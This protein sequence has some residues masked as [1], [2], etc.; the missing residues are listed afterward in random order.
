MLNLKII[1]E[2]VRMFTNELVI[3]GSVIVGLIIIFFIVMKI[4]QSK[5]INYIKSLEDEIYKLKTTVLHQEK[6]IESSKNGVHSH[7]ALEQ[8]KRVET[9][10]AEVEKQKKRVEDAKAIAQESHKIKLEFLSNI[11]E[12]ITSPMNAIIASSETLFRKCNDVELQK[13]AT[14]IY[15]LGKQLLEIIE[16]IVELSSVAKGT[17]KIE[18][19]PVDVKSVIQKI[20]RSQRDEARRKGLEL[21]LDIDDSLP[22]ALMLDREK[23]EDIFSNLVENAVKFTNHGFVHVTLL[24]NGKDIVKNS[25]NLSLIV[26]DSGPGIDLKDQKKIF[27]I[28]ENSGDDAITKGMGL[29]LS[30]HKRIAKQMNGDI[31]LESTVDKGSKF[32]FVISGVEVVLQSANSGELNVDLIDF[33]LVKPEGASIIVIDEN[34][35]L[36]N[37]VRDSFFESKIKVF[38]S[39]NLQ[40]AIDILKNNSVDMIL[41]DV[42]ILTSDDNA[43]AKILKG[44]SSAPIVTLTDRRIKDINLEVSASQIAGHLKKPLAKSELFKTSLEVLNRR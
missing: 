10:E 7:S 5:N 19:V 37:L 41:I 23:I 12:E 2:R 20:I 1:D 42:N 17:L 4:I 32:V 25:I 22:D 40:D 38:S 36:R 43:V 14:K 29:G 26:E 24:G 31:F 35:E 30:I 15:N 8:I 16:D 33:S 3:F 34:L 21:T 11:R 28:F 18:E 13:Y 6:V 9:L 39:D 27:E 44:I